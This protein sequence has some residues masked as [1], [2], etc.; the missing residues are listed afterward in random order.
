MALDLTK[1]ANNSP[2]LTADVR[3]NF[4]A[5]DAAIRGSAVTA[6]VGNVGTGEDQLASIT[7]PAGTLLNSGDWIRGIFWGKSANNANVKTVRIRV[8]EGANNTVLLAATLTVSQAGHWL[9]GFA[10]LRTGA[11]TF[12]ASAQLIVGPTNDQVTRS[13]GNV[14]SSS[15]ATWANAVEV[16]I[17]GEATANDDITIEGGSLQRVAA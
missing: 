17:T 14:T 9:L 13:V 4:S 10:I 16:R 1:P 11:T 15:T 7:V 5:L 2:A 8:I 3:A 6:T 12:R